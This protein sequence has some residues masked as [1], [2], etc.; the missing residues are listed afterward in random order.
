MESGLQKIR[1]PPC[2]KIFGNLIFWMK[3]WFFGIFI[4]LKMW[5]NIFRIFRKSRE[6][7]KYKGFHKGFSTKPKNGIRPS[8]NPKTTFCENIWK[9]DFFWWKHDFLGFS[10]FW[11]CGKIFSGFSGNPGKPPN[12]KVFTKDF[13]QNLKNGIR[14]SKNPKT[15]FCEKISGVFTIKDRFI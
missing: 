2:A 12:T 14:P 1:K 10:D 8:K 4:F 9:S 5:K 13:P 15:T 11:K 3:T 7:S 6:T